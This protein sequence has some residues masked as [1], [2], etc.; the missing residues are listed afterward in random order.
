MMYNELLSNTAVN[1]L[2]QYSRCSNSWQINPTSKLPYLLRT[3][4]TETWSFSVYAEQHAYLKANKLFLLSLSI[5]QLY[6]AHSFPH[7]S[8]TDNYWNCHLS[9]HHRHN[10]RQH[11][12]TQG[13]TREVS[14]CNLLF[15]ISAQ[16]SKSSKSN[17]T[18]T[19]ERIRFPVLCWG[20]VRQI[21]WTVCCSHR[22]TVEGCSLE[23]E[24]A[25]A[26]DASVS[27]V[28]RPWLVQWPW[29]LNS[30]C[31]PAAT[32]TQHFLYNLHH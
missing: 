7:F 1:I 32:A 21:L 8:L 9:L 10:Q 30:I 27:W 5:Q 4:F 31:L 20:R 24:T 23:S 6:S 25:L 19:L 18:L 17:K 11:L 28:A 14:W 2:Y 3:Y 26:L 29:C 16:G 22:S 15:F 12:K 13:I